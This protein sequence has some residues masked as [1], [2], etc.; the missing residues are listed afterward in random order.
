MDGTELEKY[1]LTP[2]CMVLAFYL[3][4]FP[5]FNFFLS[6]KGNRTTYDVEWSGS[7]LVWAL[8][9]FWCSGGFFFFFFKAKDTTIQI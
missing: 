8:P 6:L 1:P 2:F 5:L 7:G 4:E 3:L 9:Y